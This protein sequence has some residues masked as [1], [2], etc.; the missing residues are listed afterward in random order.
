[1]FDPAE[2]EP[3]SLGLSFDLSAKLDSFRFFE[4]GGVLI[5]IRSAAIDSPQWQTPVAVPKF[6]RPPSNPYYPHF[7]ELW[8]LLLL[9][10]DR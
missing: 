7:S 10:F 5:V 8:R 4:V 9:E 3:S 2:E 1:M 6:L